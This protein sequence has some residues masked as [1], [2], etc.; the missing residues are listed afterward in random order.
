MLTDMEIKIKGYKALNEALGKVEA[1]KFIALVMKEPF[2]YTKWQRELLADKSVEEISH[3][4]MQSLDEE[5]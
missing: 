3:A 2:D 1:E 4:A 5:S